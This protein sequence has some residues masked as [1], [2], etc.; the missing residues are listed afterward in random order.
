[1]KTIVEKAKLMYNKSYKIQ[2]YYSIHLVIKFPTLEMLESY[3]RL[4]M[5]IW[6]YSIK[7][8]CKF[9]CRIYMIQVQIMLSLSPSSKIIL[10]TII[11]LFFNLDVNAMSTFLWYEMS[12][13]WNM[14]Y[15]L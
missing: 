11:Y 2:Y 6:L 8:P 9:E 14:C 15:K 10:F 7:N 12:S 13:V 4:L 5:S 3:E 1:M